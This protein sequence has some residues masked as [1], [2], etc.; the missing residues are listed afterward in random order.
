MDYSAQ[1]SLSVGNLGSDR[2]RKAEDEQDGR[3]VRSGAPP[4]SDL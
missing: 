1:P 3:R 2:K 4:P